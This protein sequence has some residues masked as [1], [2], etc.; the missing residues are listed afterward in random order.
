MR[1]IKLD[2]TQEKGLFMFSKHHPK[3]K[4]IEKKNNPRDESLMVDLGNSSS[5]KSVNSRKNDYNKC[6]NLPFVY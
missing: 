3:F 2:Y 6:T 1:G 4:N 5:L